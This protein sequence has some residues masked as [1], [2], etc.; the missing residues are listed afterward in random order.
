[1]LSETLLK[2]RYFNAFEGYE[3]RNDWQGIHL[4]LVSF[5]SEFLGVLVS[6]L[7]KKEKARINGVYFSN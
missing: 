7:T 6:F 4:S 2:Q 3:S 5:F 1:M